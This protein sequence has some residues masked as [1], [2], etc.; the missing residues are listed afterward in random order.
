MLNG[1]KLRRGEG[2]LEESN[3]QNG[4]RRPQTP[5]GMAREEGQGNELMSD[6]SACY[7]ASVVSTRRSF[8]LGLHAELAVYFGSAETA[9][10][11]DLSSVSR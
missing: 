9:D 6:D 11:R 5:Q 3:S 4:S 8:L 1:P 7:T 10:I 2:E